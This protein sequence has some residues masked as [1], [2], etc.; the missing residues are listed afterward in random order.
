MMLCAGDF[1]SA[2]RTTEDLRV[3]SE[4][5]PFSSVGNSHPAPLDFSA[6]PYIHHAELGTSPSRYHLPC[7]SSTIGV[8]RLYRDHRHAVW[9]PLWGALSLAVR[10]RRRG[11]TGSR[12]LLLPLADG[13]HMFSCSL[14]L[15]HGKRMPERLWCRRPECTLC[16]FYTV[17]TPV[18]A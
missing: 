15:Q 8:P 5:N 14:R 6:P 18:S 16:S 7:V 13:S 11:W 10:D 17:R 12:R 2:C 1:I 4:A 3:A 9:M